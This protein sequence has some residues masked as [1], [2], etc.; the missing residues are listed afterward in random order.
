[1]TTKQLTKKHN[2]IATSV[3]AKTIKTWKDSKAKLQARIDKLLAAIEKKAPAK[4]TPEKK[5]KSEGGMSLADLA[6][7]LSI[8]PKVA[9]AKIRRQKSLPLNVNDEN[10]RWKAFDRDGD[11]HKALVTILKAGRQEVR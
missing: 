4:K 6:R 10:G 7:E 9:R 5:T 3:G 11:V 2:I 1:M 8:N